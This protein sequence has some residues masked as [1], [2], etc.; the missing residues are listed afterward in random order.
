MKSGWKNISFA[1]LITERKDR[2]DPHASEIR[3][4]RKIEKIDFSHGKIHLG[5]YKPT[6]TKQII[7]EPGDFVFSGLN[8][9]KGAASFNETD[10]RLVVS[11]NYSTCSFDDTT[12]SLDFFKH[13]MRSEIFQSLL[14]DNLKK[15]YGFTRPK[16][17]MSLSFLVPEGKSEQQKI[18]EQYEQGKTTSL[19]LQHE[20]AHQEALLGKLKQAILQEA[21][22]GKLTAD[23]RAAHPDTEPA[24]DLLKRI[25]KEKAQ[26]IAD[27]KLRKEKPL[28]KITPAEIPF[29][30]PEG[31]ALSWLRDVSCIRGGIT[32]NS[33]KRD[34]HKL[35]L[36]Y[37][38]VA[39]VYANRLELDEIKEIGLAESEIERYLLQSGDL[40]VVE[41]NGSKDQVGRI[42]VWDGS[43]SPCLHQNHLIN[44]RLLD[45]ALVNWVLLFYLSPLGR[46]V[47]E[48]QART[49]T[50]LYNLSTG[51][52]AGLPFLMPPLEEQAA[53][54]KRV[55]ALMKT[56]RAL[57]SEIEQS[58]THAAH[59]LQAVLKEAFAP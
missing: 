20:I 4:L 26:L 55:E 27:K 10:E 31:W 40:L 42:A 57:E 1:E 23:W 52:I 6:K 38:R 50:G 36:P 53:I 35:S 43:I 24:A 49:S 9:E 2:F 18:V 11:A 21:I 7:V 15:D 59:L 19:K 16:H 51:K 33:A 44:V 46:A 39:N 30:I 28:P 5:E 13:Y 17:L 45:K 8:I 25:Q 37:L 41:G 22:Q 34:G 56:C 32:K 29:D 12:V 48:D 58:R 54:V 14:K 47:L 3:G